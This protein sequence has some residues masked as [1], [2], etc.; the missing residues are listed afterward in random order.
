MTTINIMRN[1]EIVRSPRVMQLEG[2]FDV[3]PAERTELSWSVDINLPE[4]WN[5]GLIVGPSGCG[6]TTIA[7]ELFG[8]HMIDQHPW[9]ENTSILDDFPKSMSIKDI[10]SLLSSVGFSSPPSWVRPYHVLSNG[11]QFRVS[12]ARTLAESAEIAVVDEFTSVVDR[13]VAQIGSAAVSKTVRK[14]NMQ[15]VAVSCHY[16]IVDW[17]EPDW[18]Y[19]PHTGEFYTGRYLHQRP[20]IV[21]EIKRVHPDSWR[22]FAK[23]HYLDA[24]LNKTAR[25]FVA[26]VDGNPAAFAAV[27]H[28]PHPK[29]KNIKR[30]HRTVC[31]PDFQGV[32]IGNKLNETVASMCRALGYR[33]QSITGHPA[34]IKYRNNSPKW[35]MKRAPARMAI[36][37]SS[38]KLN[39]WETQSS[40]YT[41]S[42]EYVGPA[43][44]LETA[45]L[46]WG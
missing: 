26:F 42:F 33:F 11:E 4:S 21:L 29:A 1:S 7:R 13:T 28:F 38:S 16:D 24:G 34:M 30:A 25:C 27:L 23:H 3:P 36:M 5:I 31:L 6:K 41:A 20:P 43:M 37:G 40:R 19:Q 22:I 12:L 10:T 15:F 17:L 44:D 9:G 45:R 2:I 14:R 8:D 46:L 18:V 39:G 32:G 35:A